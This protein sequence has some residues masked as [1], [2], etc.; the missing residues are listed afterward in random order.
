[1]LEISGNIKNENFV[2]IILV[3]LCSKGGTFMLT[4]EKLKEMGAKEIYL[5]VTHCEN[6]IFEI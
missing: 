2:A 5:A 6:T 1:M 3:D 4:E